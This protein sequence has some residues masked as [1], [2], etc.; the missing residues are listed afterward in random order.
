MKQVF[1]LAF[2]LACVPCWAA[3]AMTNEDIVRMTMKGI[4]AVE[5]IDAIHSA[6]STAFDLDP[7]VV[8]EL[9]EAG[10][11]AAVIEAMRRAGAPA[12]PS[13]APTVAAAL[14]RVPV[15]LHLMKPGKSADQPPVEGPP[16]VE[17]PAH[18]PE[19]KAI[20][21]AFFLMCT[22]PRHVPDG[23]T[24]SPLAQGLPRHHLLWI[25]DKL[26]A[27]GAPPAGEAARP[28]GEKSGG[29]GGPRVLTLELPATVTLQ[30]DAGSH[31]IVLG[32]ALRLGDDPWMTAGVAEGFLSL[33]E[34]SPVSLSVVVSG[35]LT[36]RRTRSTGYAVKIA[37]SEPASA[38]TAS[39][40]AE[41]EP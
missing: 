30:L 10:V 22:D 23:W 9:M 39:P 20:R 15:T 12:S 34:G 41:S 5:I 31:P 13:P 40:P 37:G 36:G 18:V 26:V 17:V 14:P 2:A 4:P 29:G 35:R 33:T 6:P 3:A 27:E 28:T 38:F 32:L 19:G 1:L 16:R 7:D 24:A 21:A 11:Q 8:Q 25:A